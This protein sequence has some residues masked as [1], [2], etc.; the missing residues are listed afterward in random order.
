MVADLTRQPG[1]LENVNDA[2]QAEL[3]HLVHLALHAGRLSLQLV[4][5]AAES[6]A[7][8]CAVKLR[9]LQYRCACRTKLEACR[10][11]GYADRSMSYV[12]LARK[13]RP[14]SFADLVGQ[15]HVSRTLANAIASDRVAHAFLFTGVRGVGKT[16]SAR[17]LAKALNCEQ[18]PT[19]SPCLKCAPCLQ[20]GDGDDVDVREIDGASYNGVD[21]VRRLQESLPYRPARDRFKIFIVDEVH[22]LSTAAWNAF[23]KTL[24]E[25]PPHVKFIF[26]TTE[27]H[28]VPV[29]ILSRCQ[30]FDFKLIGVAD[31]S[32]RLR[33]VLDAE[34]V[35][36][37]DAAIHIVAREAA[38]S[39]RDAM[40]LLDQLI[41][42]VG[43]SNESLSVEVTARVLGVAARSV[44]HQLGA[45]LIDGEASRC[46]DLVAEMAEQSYAL[47]NVARDFLAHLRNLVVAK[48][49]D[50]PAQLLDLAD[51]ELNDV[52][53]LSARTALEDLSRLYLGFSRAFDDIVRSAQPRAAFEMALVR[54]SRRP[55]LLPL[56]ELMRRL[57]DLE[58]RMGSAPGGGRGPAGPSG[59]A[60]KPA[61]P[62][63]AMGGSRGAGGGPR[64]AGGR[65]G[66]ATGGSH[67]SA[68]EVRAP[69]NAD[70][71]TSP[72]AT[73]LPSSS[74]RGQATA[75][76]SS[77]A[78]PTEP[79][80]VARAAQ[81]PR[82]PQAAAKP[83]PA[84]QV[85][86][87][88]R[89]E[90]EMSEETLT[91]W[92]AILAIVAADKAPVASVF[93][94]GS[95]LVVQSGRI[96]LGYKEGSF[97]V[98]QASA[99]PATSLL[100][101]AAQQ[102]FGTPCEIELDLSGKHHQVQTMAAKNSAELAA[103]TAAAREQVAQQPAV[104]MAIEVLGAELQQVR[105]PS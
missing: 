52:V 33:H 88:Q 23:L 96:V 20:I 80:A 59:S 21:E 65:P 12:V 17:I 62:R 101:A 25:P 75:D 104:R 72:A 100:G 90:R 48:V 29:T 58:R 103:R 2:V 86:V 49:S 89:F 47:A 82:P 92:R 24:E 105:L 63:S 44:L 71:G 1:D 3:A 6:H 60:G 38:G 87:P 70:R 13:W 73:P 55:P 61:D 22:M 79:G 8:R 78:Q 81:S 43:G 9:T 85:P 53:T 93:E 36:A 39:M 94:H 5:S 77:Q 54:L 74:A 40:S 83:S 57:A 76:V 35:D 51:S 69:A 14:Q 41:A 34:K 7:C 37:E 27:V 15:E 97:L 67:G 66:S 11:Q 19:A 10:S 30:R 98:Q 68:P 16:T 4:H 31:I 84:Q 45:A 64:G 26:A 18:G 50:K 102:H 99:A 42:W 46:L 91:A 56:D 95:P 28:K 32:A